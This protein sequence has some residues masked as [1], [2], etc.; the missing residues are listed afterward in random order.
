MSEITSEPKKEKQPD[1]TAEILWKVML[2]MRFILPAYMLWL[3]YKA[4]G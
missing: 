2:S 1:R 3:F 4:F